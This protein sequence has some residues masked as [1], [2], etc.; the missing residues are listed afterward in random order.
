MQNYR[1]GSKPRRLQGEIPALILKFLKTRPGL[2][3]GPPA[4]EAT[5]RLPPSV[6]AAALAQL[7]AEDRVEKGYTSYRDPIYAAP[8]A[9]LRPAPK[10]LESILTRPGHHAGDDRY[11]YVQVSP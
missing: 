2:Y 8:A 11:E 1:T 5:L 4:I 9:P 7:V 6:V 10:L 3:H